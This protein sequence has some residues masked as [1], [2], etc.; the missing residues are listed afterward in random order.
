MKLTGFLALSMNRF[1]FKK[2]LTRKIVTTVS[3]SLLMALGTLTFM[4][5]EGKRLL[6]VALPEPVE[7]ADTSVVYEPLP[8]GLSRERAD[9][10]KAVDILAE[11]AE[12]NPQLSG[13]YKRVVKRLGGEAVKS[14]SGSGIRAIRK[15]NPPSGEKTAVADTPAAYQNEPEALKGYM[16]EG[17]VAE[18][19]EP[20]SP[21]PV[22][23]ISIEPLS[24][25]ESL[26]LTVG[27]MVFDTNP[28]VEKWVSHYAVSTGGRRTLAVGI[29]RSNQYLEMAREEFRR[30]GVPE[31]L[32]WL[33]LVESVWNP[34]AVSP[35]AAGGIWQFI[36]KTAKE[37]GLKVES[38][39]DERGDPVKQTRVAA[40]YL[41]DL[42][43]IFGDWALAMAA[44]NCGEPR[45]MKA[46]VENGRAN[47]W[48]ICEKRLLPE[49]TR[50]YVPKI[51]AAIK[52]VGRA[53][54]MGLTVSQN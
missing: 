36:P 16:T 11:A 47:Y 17:M 23:S 10:K 52:V 8:K 38:G 51:L 9:F 32:V 7:T 30:A 15:F 24:S 27:D 40:A 50:N 31:D 13:Y 54:V 53:D 35:A 25:G 19:G 49:E 4:S 37:Y 2:V 12:A 22:E 3:L 14:E 21:E 20:T 34:R 43:T 42:Y 33:A 18:A 44:Y 5:P 28:A 48:E 46:V 6:S 26:P 39:N 45:V 29:E 41:R 1:S